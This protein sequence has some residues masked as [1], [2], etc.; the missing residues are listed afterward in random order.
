[1]PFLRAQPRYIGVNKKRGASELLPSQASD[2]LNVQLDNGTIKKRSGF[3]EITDF[4]GPALGIFDFRRGDG[5]VRTL[6]KHGSKLSSWDNDT[7]TAT[8]LI[9]DLDRDEHAS[10]A[11]HSDKCYFVDGTS[12]KVTNGDDSAGTRDAH[13]T[14]PTAP[15]VAV[16]DTGTLSGTYDYQVTFFDS[17]FQQESPASAASATVSPDAQKVDLTSI[18]TSGSY[19]RK[20]YR[21][22]TSAHEV[23]WYYI[24]TIEDSTTTT[25]T[26]DILD[27]NVSLTEPAPLHYTEDLPGFR[28]LEQHSGIM[29]LAGDDDRLFFTQVDQ[30]WSVTN[31]IRVG[32]EGGIGKI[33]GLKSFM[34]LLVVFKEDSIWTLSGVD[35]ET[36][37]AKLIL[38]GVGCAGGHSIVPAGNLLYFLGEDAFYVFDGNQVLMISDP[39]QPDLLTRNRARDS[40]VVGVND[41]DNQAIIWSWSSSGST[42]NDQSA[43]FFYGNTTKM[44][45]PGM[46]PHHSWSP[47]KFAIPMT[48]CARVTTSSI[49]RDRRVWYGF[50][51]GVVGEPGGDSDNGSS[52]EFKWQ[53]GKWDGDV[54]E[55][56]KNWGE[57]QVELIQQ[58]NPSYM[59]IRHYRDAETEYSQ[60]AVLDSK[61]P[62]NDFLISDYSRDIR[63]EFY[64]NQ[65]IPVELVSFV[66]QADKAGR[67]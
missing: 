24:A 27:V 36:F 6:I 61:V 64:Q 47:W 1:M 37:S 23:N 57:L 60:I 17:D 49:A 54:P 31:S 42:S 66:L 26:D 15:T 2:A 51:N 41:E 63:I 46:Q 55:L 22:K 10:F 58:T 39:I 33:T 65:A 53:T 28:Y 13:I 4:A 14:Y 43:A 56:L 30:P 9:S 34:G 25:Y 67:A 3:T 45:E 5:T 7:S 52:I 40:S 11:V 16:G 59:E 50:S 48:S 12:L 29:F 32:G 35:I 19:Y 44:M 38:N 21:R 62:V 8:T 18:Q 20:I